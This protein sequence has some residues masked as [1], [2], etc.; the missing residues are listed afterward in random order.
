MFWAASSPMMR[1]S[2]APQF[3]L[4][5]GHFVPL[6]EV[7]AGD[8]SDDWRGEDIVPR[9]VASCRP[10]CWRRAFTAAR[11]AH[12]AALRRVMKSDGKPAEMNVSANG[13]APLV[14]AILVTLCLLLAARQPKTS[15]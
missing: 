14:F 11:S 5:N 3:S 10:R 6:S 1:M 13:A 2:N 12:V 15:S 4:V 9:P 8:G 7:A